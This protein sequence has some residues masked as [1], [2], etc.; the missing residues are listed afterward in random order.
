MGG[1]SWIFK[2]ERLMR[3]S[4]K[5]QFAKFGSM[6]TLRS[7]NWTRKEACPIQ[8]TATWPCASLGN[9]GRRC[10][11]VRRVSKVFQTIS[12]KNVRGL[13]CLAGVRSLKDFGSGWLFG[14]GGLG[15]VS[16][17]L[18]DGHQAPPYLAY[19]LQIQAH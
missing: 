19:E 16:S 6:R 14:R 1:R 10:C 2:P 17:V 18:A 12:W 3:L 15:I 13:K 5:S 9:T 8:V 11:P 7:V 4:R